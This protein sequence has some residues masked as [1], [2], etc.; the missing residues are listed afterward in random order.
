MGKKL[1]FTPGP[2]Q[3]F[4]TVEQHIK[5]ALKEDIP[6]ISH[7]SNQ[8]QNTFVYTVDAIRA[9]LNVPEDYRI[10]FTGSATEVWERAIQNLV[11]KSSHHFVNGSFSKRFYE[12]AQAYH[13][14]A[15]IEDKS[16]GGAFSLEVP[17]N[18][19]LIAITQNETSIGFN[20]PHEE[21]KHVRDNNPESLLAIDMV[22]CTPAVPLD[23]N[24]VDLAYFS[25]QK[26]FGLPAGL[27]VWI[28]S[29]RCIEKA[30]K[31]EAEGHITGSYH[32][33][34]QLLKYAEKNQTPETPNVLYIYLLG[35]VAN[36]ML[37]RGLKQI[38]N[39]TVYKS[40]ILYQMM[41]T[42]EWIS[43]F[44]EQ[45]KYQSKTVA[46]GEINGATPSEII[47]YGQEKA[48][49]I[50]SGYGP[51]KEEHIRIANFPTHSREQ[52]EMLVDHLM[53][54]SK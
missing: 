5:T 46:V 25:V 19:E 31:L 15:T 2:A 4:Y 40:T 27:G 48:M 35:Q 37:Q 7:R 20:F 36:D 23:L 13:I 1:F 50:G 6:S 12:I 42:C 54:F 39:D 16:Y 47:A 24:L 45:D 44:I 30:Q 26:S 49:V 22:S 28:F 53:K 41:K 38:Q 32:T 51:Y 18:P 21:I 9:L 43:P 10:V 34:T 52:V 17:G 8:F 11:K 33:I 3:L 29:P 14:E